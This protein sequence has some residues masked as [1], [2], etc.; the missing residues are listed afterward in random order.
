[1]RIGLDVAQHQLL[2]PELVERVI[3]AEQSG[4]D[5]AWVFD[6]FTPLYGT[7]KGPCLEAWTLLAGLAASTSR[8]RLGVL[9]TGIT[10][11]HPSILATEAI[12][13]D[14]ISNGRLE[15]GLGAAWHQPE[16]EQLGI[17]FP[18]IKERADRLEEGVQVMRLLMTKDRASFAGR[19]YQLDG[20]S[21]HPKAVQTPHP[22]I[23]IGAG[24]EQLMLPIVARQADAWHAFGSE[25]TMT[26]KS[27]LLDQLAEKAGR[28]PRGI[29]RS[30]S[31]SLSR[32]WDQ[33]R[34]RAASLRDAGFGYLV[35][36]W[37]SEGKGRLEDFVEKVMP[38][39][40]A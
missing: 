32:P 25:Q 38:E 22:P 13:A 19:Y 18:P 23:W 2:W 6:H 10:Y 29:L 24:G 27:R 17:P 15:I 1:M 37:P 16:H 14:H 5:G 11:R 30:A 26:G 39:I 21:Y 9:V 35:A 4:F 36:E 8:I 33:V 31:L 28:D 3:F 20:A 7:P 40:A 12:T 34:R